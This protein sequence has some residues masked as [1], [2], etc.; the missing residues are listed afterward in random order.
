MI[1]SSTASP[2]IVIDANLGVRAVLPIGMR[3]VMVW[4]EKLRS[5]RISIFA[6]DLWLAETVSAIRRI[7][8]LK[9]ITNEE[10]RIAIQDLFSLGVHILPSDRELCLSA[11]QWADQLGQSKAYDGLYLALASR[12]SGEL[13]NSIELWTDDDHLASRAD[14]LGLRFIRR[15]GT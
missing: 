15:F 1:S 7:T 3:D 10:G 6:P 13:G 5:T 8:Y 4:F 12:L 9:L 14:Q 2:A 11:Y